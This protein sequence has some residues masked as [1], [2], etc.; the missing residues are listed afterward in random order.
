MKRFSMMVASFVFVATMCFA[1]E[2]KKAEGVSF[3]KLSKYLQLEPAQL[4]E[5]SMIYAYFVNQLGQPLSGEALCNHPKP[6]NV[7]NA[8]I[9]NLKLMKRTL[10][11]GQYRK[12]VALINVTRANREMKT[13]PSLLDSYLA[14]K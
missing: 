2:S 1:Q 11:P 3:D 4:E 9:C 13:S 7:Q 5:A 12:Y 14:E 6:E 8:L 10:T